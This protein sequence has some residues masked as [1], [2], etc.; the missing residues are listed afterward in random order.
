MDPQVRAK[1]VQTVGDALA[2]LDAELTLGHGKAST[3]AAAALRAGLKEHGR[4]IGDKLDSLAQASLAAADEL[5]AWQR[6][7]ADQLRLDLV[8]KAEALFEATPPNE[9]GEPQPA[10]PRVGGR[11]MQEALRSLRELWKQT[12]LGG[13]PNHGLWRRFDEAC[14]EAHKVV[15]AWLERIRAEAAQTKAQRLALIDE[16]KAW[17]VEVQKRQIPHDWKA[18][19]RA[20][21]QFGDRWRDAGHLGE[22]A[23]AEL[24]PLWRAAIDL[25][26]GPLHEA[27]AQSLA[28]RHALIEEAVKLG[29]M[30]VLRID[31]IKAL[32]QQWQTLAQGVPMERKHEQKLWDAFRKPIDDAFNRKTEEREKAAASLSVRD[33][34]VISAAKALDAANASGDAQKIRAAM[35]ELEHALWAQEQGPAAA[36]ALPANKAASAL[37]LAESAS[38]V[39]ASDSPTAEAPTDALQVAAPVETAADSTLSAEPAEQAVAAAPPPPPP[40]VVKRVIAVRGDDRPGMKKSEPMPSGRHARPGERRDGPRPGAPRG[41]DDRSGPRRDD[42]GPR[43]DGPSRTAPDRRDSERPAYPDR[44]P[45][46]GDAAFR[47]QREAMEQADIALRKLAARAHGEAL[48]GL[49][50][51][52]EKRSAE[53]LPSQQE[54]GRAVSGGLRTAWVQAVGAEAKSDLQGMREALIR[55]EMAAELATP[56]DGLD[57][58]RAYQLKLLTRRNDPPPAQTWGQDAAKVFAN[59]FDAALVRRL[60]AALKVLLRG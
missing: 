11:K 18:F 39:A 55:L 25:A 28:Q 59:G 10:K 19:S 5:G 51:A 12:D 36:Q 2:K 37:P 15:E 34:A 56:A 7:R 40:P 60:Q 22:K 52:W 6:W 1:A 58:R 43:S 45:R 54:L 49:I 16:I 50:G 17:T 46:L 23:F 27:Q 44:G 4:L 42:R 31:A 8:K 14:N 24:Q 47:A 3:E 13:V 9:A 41:A 38:A 33:Q 35:A 26:A 20:L 30:P 32:Q 48:T 53:A 21:H 57:E 29:A